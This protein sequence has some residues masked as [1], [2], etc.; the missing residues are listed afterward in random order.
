M[1]TPLGIIV[2][3][4]AVYRMRSEADIEYP[5]GEVASFRLSQLRP[6]PGKA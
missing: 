6:L 3:I 1:R 5:N 2:T 4:T